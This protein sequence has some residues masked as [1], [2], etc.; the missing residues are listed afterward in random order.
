M[1][2]RVL[3]VSPNFPPVNA[4]DHQRVRMSLPYHQQYGWQA[5][6]LAVDPA[7][8]P[9][10]L[11]N[12][13][14]LTI[15]DSIS[16]TR[17]SALPLWLTRR[18]GCGSLALRAYWH[19]AQA[20]ARLLRQEKFD[21][22]YFSTTAFLT[23]ALG[24]VWKRRFGVPYVLDM[25]DPWVS[26]YYRESGNNPPGGWLKYGFAQWLARR[27][28]PA[29][30]REAGHIISVSPAYPKMLLERYPE[31]SQDCFTVLPFGASE[32]D[33]E[34]VRERAIRH[35]IFNLD[36]GRLHWTYL[37][38]GGSDMALSLRG[39]FL[40]L[41]AL[42][43]FH[44]L[45]EKLQLHFVGTS[46]AVAHQAAK[47]VEPLAR[48][49]GVSDLV[50]EQ[51]QRIPYL[52]GL[53]LLQSS[54]AI[55]IVGS[56]DPSYSASKVYPCILARRP[57]LAIL[58]ERSLAGEVVRACQAGESIGFSSGQIPDHI[59]DSIRPALL[60]LLDLPRGSV[61]PTNWSAFAPYTA[62]EMT[63]RQCQVFDRV[64]LNNSVRSCLPS[65]SLCPNSQEEIRP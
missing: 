26:N 2:P 60:R 20:G 44:P 10:T 15:P 61:P 14:L 27:A 16:V 19:I 4:A 64:V 63:G 29:A 13:L 59:A 7:Y 25:Q 48:E 57:V 37:G 40:A 30:M 11:D 12:D 23:M 43:G 34:T 24:P 33:F 49:I 51:T 22:V 1:P 53:D 6:V 45:V 47:T 41:R 32:R 52:Q 9:T 46:Y 39:L 54:D 21:L 35:S 65:R 58:H 42:R 8:N 56:D 31:L 18:I 17:V 55:L 5:H 62:R 3:I 50:S 36:D 28:E 38:R